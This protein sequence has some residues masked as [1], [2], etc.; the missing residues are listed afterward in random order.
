LARSSLHQTL[1]AA[2]WKISPIDVFIASFFA[3]AK[4]FGRIFAGRR[5]RE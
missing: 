5:V 4:N 1:E 2:N 3:G